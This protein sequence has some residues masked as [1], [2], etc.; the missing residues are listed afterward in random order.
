MEEGREGA[1]RAVA[2]CWQ[3]IGRRELAKVVPTTLAVDSDSADNRQV[4][5]VRWRQS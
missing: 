3:K 1:S 4:G 5:K 2:A